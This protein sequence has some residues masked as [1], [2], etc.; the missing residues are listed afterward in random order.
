[1]LTCSDPIAG[2]HNDLYEIEKNFEEMLKVLDNAGIPTEGLFLNADAG[3][4]SEGMR[5]IC[6]ERGI[7]LNIAT[8]KRNRRSEPDSDHIFDEELY[9]NR[10]VIERSNAWLDAFKTLLV[11][12]ETKARHW[13]GWHF[14]AF[15]V[16]ML[17][18]VYKNQKV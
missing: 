16:N 15:C 11:R 2:N 6:R 17:R 12:Y 10:Y 3:F 5:K 7:I 18:N 13:K 8:N 9:K 14:L 4:D 1:V